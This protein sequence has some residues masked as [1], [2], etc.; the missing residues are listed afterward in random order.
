MPLIFDYGNARTKFHALYLSPIRRR[1]TL[2]VVKT[3]VW[4]GTTFVFVKSFCVTQNLILAALEEVTGQTGRVERM[5]CE[6]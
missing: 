1:R 5:T 4:T 3:L 6:G 2:V